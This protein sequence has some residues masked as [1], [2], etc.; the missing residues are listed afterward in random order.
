MRKTL[1]AGAAAL[2][3]TM[4]CAHAQAQTSTSVEGVVVTA[5]T[6]EDTLPEQLAETG[7]KVDVIQSQAIRNGGYPD[8]ATALQALAPSLFVLPKNGP[9][10]YVDL[11]LLGSRTEDVLWMVDGVRINNRLY[12]GTTPLDTMPSGMV[13]RLEV[14]DG[15]QALFYGTQAVAGAVNI[16][17]KPF[18]KSLTGMVEGQVDTNTARHL[19]GNV[20]DAYSFGQVVLYASADQSD[21]YKAFRDQDYQPSS[22]HRKR[23]YDVYTEGLKYGLD[24][25]DQLRL[26][27]SY[28]RTDG[29]LDFAS[30]YRVAVDVNNRH[31]DLATGKI[32]YQVNDRLGFF[33][34]GYWHNWHTTYD[35]FYNDLATPGTLD[36]LYE[37]AFWGFWDYGVNALG[38][39]D[40]AKGVEGYFGYDY[41]S[42]G[43][44]DEVLV[45]SQHD[46]NTHAV[47]GQ[48]RLTPDLIPGVNLAG[49]FRYNDPSVG[50]SATIWNVS[51]KY[52][53]P[54][55]FY[56]KG[57]AGTN[58]RLPTAE[59]LFANDPLDE[60]GNPN[61]KPERSTGGNL[62]LGWR[63]DMGGHRMGVEVTGFARDI[64]DL[65]DY[66]TFD[67]VTQQDVF[68]NVAGT[69][70]VRGGQVTADAAATDAVSA[71]LTYSANEAKQDGG[72][73]LDRIP[74]SLFKAGLDWHP[75]NLPVGA[76]LNVVY[77]GDV[78]RSLGGFGEVGYGDYTVVDLSGRYFL[79]AG[80]HQQLNISIRNLFDR[81]Y[82]L[83]A[84]G[85]ADTPADGPYDCS[86]PYVY[87]NLGLPRTFAVSYSY[88][89]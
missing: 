22:T 47:F 23:T 65:I 51:G 46:E 4:T 35:Q 40:I 87:Q 30:P 37:G 6:L 80:R 63:F 53:S 62:S 42:Y 55:G 73:Q 81:R 48:L 18:S 61:L 75:S 36:K 11:S 68:G 74:R 70:R 45:I 3:M 29:A 12:A 15:G 67:S 89:F 52:Q 78:S 84:R 56:V 27:A 14:L 44:R 54:V 72:R 8:I 19:E 1:M 83:P 64:T 59:E 21:G 77:T 79:D 5:R 43:G 50:Q 16:V 25:T 39:L 49:G 17:T 31:E 66:D 24:V 58:F 13:D 10:D 7:V 57:E 26:S 71:N 38:K 85:C 28:Q 9:F 82:G 88:R 76:S 41:Q 33:V 32:D 34:K 60:R 2:G 86:I 69:V 20:A